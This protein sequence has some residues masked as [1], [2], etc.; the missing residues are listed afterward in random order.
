[1]V[2]RA[3]DF[4]YVSSTEDYKILVSNS[5]LLKCHT[6]MNIEALIFLSKAGVW[7]KIESPL[8][9]HPEKFDQGVVVN[10]TLHW[11]FDD[12]EVPKR[13]ANHV[14]VCCGGGGSGSLYVHA[15]RYQ[16]HDAG[17]RVVESVECWVTRE[18]GATDSWAKCLSCIH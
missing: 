13:L 4:G 6:D 9:F 12:Y 15:M 2:F 3:L 17:F 5:R 10:E 8:M 14:E 11:I 16:H 1:M 18:Y 7:R